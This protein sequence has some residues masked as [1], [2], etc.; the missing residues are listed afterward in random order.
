MYL[1]FKQLVL[2]L[3]HYVLDTVFYPLTCLA[4]VR[5]VV[6]FNNFKAT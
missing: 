2:A 3:W 1:K 5:R 6:M 4:G